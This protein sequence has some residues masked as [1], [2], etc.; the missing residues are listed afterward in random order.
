[1]DFDCALHMTL[2]FHVGKID[3]VGLVTGK[4][5]GEVA[6]RRQKWKLAAEKL[7]RLAQVMHGVDVDFIDHRRLARVRGRTKER[8]FAAAP[9][10]QCNRQ[11]AFDRADASVESEFADEA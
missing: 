5:T 1:C 10:F 3:I 8:L 2:S 4:E 7:K 9:R 6:A 11:N